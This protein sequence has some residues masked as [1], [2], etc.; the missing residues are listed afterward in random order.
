VTGS[1]GDRFQ[2]LR[3]VEALLFA[4]AEP[5]SEAALAQ[6]LPE[7]TDLAALLDELR[8][9]Y[10]NRGV[11]LVQVGGRWAFRTASDLAPLLRVETTTRRRLSRAAIETLAVIAYHQPVTR[12][13]IEEIR[14]VS[15]SRGLLEILLEAGWIRIGRRRQTPGRPVTWLTT[16]KFLDHF[17]LTS[18]EDLPGI[19]ELKAAG[20]L[21][22]RPALEAFGS[23]G[24]RANPLQHEDEAGD[25]GDSGSENAP[26]LP[27][28]S[29]GGSEEP[30]SAREG[31]DDRDSATG[32]LGPAESGE[33]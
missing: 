15:M 20:L 21:D 24:D 10:A 7:E 19:E 31:D 27:L 18:R 26:R 14:G 22:K 4:S 25:S 8:G 28:A 16:E 5:V 30:P 29:G 12:A 33:G 17:G 1:A 3:L 11:R 23:L 13:E 6:R 9:L 2:Q 32:R